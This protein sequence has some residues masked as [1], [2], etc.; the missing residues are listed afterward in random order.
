[1]AELVKHGCKWLEIKVR[2][3]GWKLLEWLKI[4]EGGN[5]EG[6][7][8]GLGDPKQKIAVSED[9]RLPKR[10][11]AWPCLPASNVWQYAGNWQQPHQDCT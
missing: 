7:G 5:E 4:V 2:K 3:N 9:F 8:T 10:A 1:M 11:L 6:S